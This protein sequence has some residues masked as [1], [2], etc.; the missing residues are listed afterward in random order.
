M[1]GMRV[2]QNRADGSRDRIVGALV[3]G[4]DPADLPGDSALPAIK[5]G[6]LDTIGS[7]GQAFSEFLDQLIGDRADLVL[8]RGAF[9]SDRW[10]VTWPGGRAGQATQAV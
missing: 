4:E 1:C 8:D 6:E 2:L 3:A 9:G 7:G 5:F 10:I